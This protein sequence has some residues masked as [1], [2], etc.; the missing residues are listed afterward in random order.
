MIDKHTNNQTNKQIMT[1]FDHTALPKKC[2]VNCGY[3]IRVLA[4]IFAYHLNK[5]SIKIQLLNYVM[6]LK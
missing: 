3:F 2:K 6:T 4:E 1:Y 5:S